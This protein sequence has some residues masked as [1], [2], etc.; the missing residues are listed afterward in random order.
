MDVFYFF[1]F[2]CKLD[3][4]SECIEY[5]KVF[6]IS[7]KDDLWLKLDFSISYLMFYRGENESWCKNYIL[8]KWKEQ[9]NFFVLVIKASHDYEGCKLYFCTAFT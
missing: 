9:D 6:D 5:C 2:F 1:I 3:A 7:K 8:N 4:Y